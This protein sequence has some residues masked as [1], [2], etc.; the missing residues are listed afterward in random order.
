[1]PKYLGRE[2]SVGF[3]IQSG[4]GDVAAQIWMRHLKNGLKTVVNK[5]KNESAMGRPEKTNG[6]VVTTRWA[7]GPI[8]AKLQDTSIGFLFTSLM[9]GATSSVNDDASE[10]VYDHEFP[11]VSGVEKLLTVAV[12]NLVASR[13]YPTAAVSS[14]EITS[15]AGSEGD[16]VMVAADLVTGDRITASNTVAYPDPGEN[17]FTSAHVSAKL[18]AN[19]A[20][21]GAASVL[22]TKSIKLT[23]SR[24]RTPFVPHFTKT[25]V[26]H[27]V[28]PLVVTGEL[29]LRYKDTT[30]EDVQYANDVRVLLISIINTDVTIGTA[31]HP[32]MTFTGHVRD[33]RQD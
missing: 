32:G 19:L 17:E 28:E 8:E 6:S 11:V 30:L 1:M 3:G 10:D 33:L 27:D 23:I 26:S 13:R 31:A 12:K 22:E 24:A 16:Y 21:L 18:A 5:K 15:E 9:G 20:G 2:E 4:S 29:V 7:E 25:P 14:I